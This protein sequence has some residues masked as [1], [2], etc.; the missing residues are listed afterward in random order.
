MSSSEPAMKP[1]TPG[2]ISSGMLPRPKAT[3]GQPESIASMRVSPNGSFQSIGA[4]SARASRSSG[5]FCSV[6]M[7]PRQVTCARPKPGLHLVAR[8]LA[9][10]RVRLAGD[11]DRHAGEAGGVDRGVRPLLAGEASDE[12]DV[13]PRALVQR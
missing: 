9:V 12:A 6:P 13:R 2:S 3:T 1:V 8:V 4:S 5:T 10:R 11:A 7:Q